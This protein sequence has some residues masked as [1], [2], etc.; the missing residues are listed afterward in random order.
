MS[1][2]FESSHTDARDVLKRT[3]GVHSKLKGGG[4]CTK[5]VPNK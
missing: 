2:Q 3:S 4:E 5:N 1:T